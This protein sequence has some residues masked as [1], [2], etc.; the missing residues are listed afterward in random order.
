M[1][2][3]STAI[4]DPSA[5]LAGDV[6]IGPFTIVE[7]GVRI[8]PGCVVGPHCVIAGGTT[9]GSGNHFFSNAQ[10]GALPQD[11]KHLPGVTGR[12][13]IGD[14]NIFRESVTVSSGTVYQGDDHEK[15]TRIGSNCLLMA[16]SHVAH[17]CAVGNGVILANS[18]A[19]AGHVTVHDK[20][21]IG[22]LTGVH[23]FVVIGRN[24]FIGGM[25]RV[26]QDAL[27]YMIT[28]GADARCHGPNKIGL[29]RSGFTPEG[30][31]RIKQIYKLLCR[32]DLNTTQALEAIERDVEDSEERR[33]LVD[34]VRASTRGVT[35]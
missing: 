18:V 34:F 7:A 2:I 29:E 17:D 31:K 28:D 23:Q 9:I 14:N 32:S 20:A 26:R 21:I 33:T 12:T 1:R 11:L 27:P 3:H 30:I 8:G 5:E 4:V 25:T 16:C 6:E 22:G 15:V 24:A 10:I 35:K 19:L 13:E